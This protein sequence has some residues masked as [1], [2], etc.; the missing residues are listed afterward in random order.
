[1]DH[2][3][4]RTQRAR[5]DGEVVERA[6][7]KLGFRKT[8]WWGMSAYLTV[9][10]SQSSLG[11]NVLLIMKIVC[12]GLSCA[13]RHLTVGI[14]IMVSFLCDCRSISW[15]VYVW[16]IFRLMLKWLLSPAELFEMSLGLRNMTHLT[17][18]VRKGNINCS[19][20]FIRGN[21]SEMAYLKRWLILKY[22][23]TMQSYSFFTS[24]SFF[25]LDDVKR[26]H[27]F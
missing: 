10:F 18:A 7:R 22:I 24:S 5:W 19:Q 25:L 20:M 23:C 12:N 4:H 13:F 26:Y 17:H 27:S 21:A 2:L 15:L 6:R 1:M 3:Q 14:A 8:C 11:L 9:Q 16:F